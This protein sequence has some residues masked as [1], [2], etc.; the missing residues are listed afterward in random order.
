M[1]T[2]LKRL[3][4]DRVDLVPEGANS[5]AFVTLYKGKEMKSMDASEIL[6]KLKPEHAEV[7]KSAFAEL[8]R[9]KKQAEDE[10][11]AAKKEAA[12]A[13]AEAAK[14]PAGESGAAPT[15]EDEANKACGEKTEKKGEQPVN[16]KP[17]DAV[18]AKEG[19][20]SFDDTETLTKGLDPQ[21]AAYIEQIKKQKEAAE[22]AAREAIAKER[23]MNAVNKAA[24]LKA[25]P[26]AADELISFIEK[27]SDETV[28]MLSAI[29]KGIE[30]T[31][32]SEVGKSTDKTF[33]ASS[34]DAWARIEKA[35]EK[36]AAERNVSVAKATGMVIKEQPALYKEYLEGGAN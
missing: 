3:K 9:Q 25:L 2:E 23:H 36:L 15:K 5:A 14:K 30:G 20:T 35:A 26:I 1:P 31:V 7:L 17:S 34:S 4:I 18:K 12:V 32:L 27:S 6:E 16:G 11:A 28:D 13:K 29:A 8:E 24:E 22:E 21:V 19:T 10:A 33:S